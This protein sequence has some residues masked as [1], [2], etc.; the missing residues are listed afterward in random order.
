MQEHENKTANHNDSRRPRQRIGAA[1]FLGVERLRV[2]HEF[3]EQKTDSQPAEVSRVVDAKRQNGHNH[4]IQNHAHHLRTDFA[5][6]SSAAARGH[7]QHYADESGQRAGCADGHAESTVSEQ[8][9][10]RAGEEAANSGENVDEE[11]PGRSI[12]TLHLRPDIHQKHG[13]EADVDQAAVQENRED[14]PPP[15]AGENGYGL[16]S[17][18][19]I[20]DPAVDTAKKIEGSRGLAGSQNADAKEQEIEDE[21]ERRNR[22]FVIAKDPGELFAESGKGKAQAGATFVAARGLDA[23]KSAAHGAKLRAGL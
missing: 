14:E 9:P 10:C 12:Q 13:V 1:E 17:A 5:R 23:H 8:V 19:T 21:D 15:F 11:I 4:E 6:V 22:N 18:H 7:S 2:S 3:A 20:E 16:A